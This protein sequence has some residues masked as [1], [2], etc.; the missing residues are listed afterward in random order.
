MASVADMDCL[1]TCEPI[2]V[3]RQP[4][5][6]ARKNL[7][8][9]ELL[10]RHCPD[11]N[12]A[13]CPS[14]ELATH[15]VIADGYNL[16]HP[17][18]RPGIKVCIN[19]PYNLLLEDSAFALPP[20]SSVIEI[21]ETVIPDA[22]ILER[23]KK[24]KANGYTTSLDD[25][26]GQDGFDELLNLVDIIKV[27]V[28]ALGLDQVQGVVDK[29]RHLPC[30]LLAEKVED[31]NVFAATK[32]M[33]FDFFQG[34][35]FSKPLVIPGFKISSNQMSRVKLLAELSNAEFELQN[36]AQIIRT[37]VALTY[38]LLQFINSTHF[39]LPNKIQSVQGALN[40]LGRRNALH[41]LRVTILADLNSSDQGKELVWLSVYRARFLE[42]IAR[43]GKETDLSPESMFLW[44]LFSL[45]DVMLKRPMVDV[46]EHLPLDG[47]L[48]RHIIDPERSPCVWLAFLMAQEHAYWDKG[49]AILKAKNIDPADIATISSNALVWSAMM[50]GEVSPA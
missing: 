2:F 24:L 37:D 31:V 46:L 41:W 30:K 34:F 6:T 13:V 32:A 40:L 16:A 28:L 45:L 14:P 1:G 9:Y 50:L 43:E 3:A 17:G 49:N 19:F 22:L 25:F 11:P 8:G 18:I 21:L 7:W 27:D 44:G 5:F 47:N 48:K 12:V 35:F 39:S 38:R 29:I 33:G 4:I 42:L 15:Q 10:F 20:E 26:V 23:V 36:L